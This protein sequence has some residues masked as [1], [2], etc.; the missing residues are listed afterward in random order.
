MRSTVL[1]SEEA[2]APICQGRECQRESQPMSK[3]DFVADYN[4]HARKLKSKL[5]QDQ[6]M[7][8]AIGGQ[9]IPFG[10]LEMNLL[11]QYGLIGN[12]LVIDVGCGSGRLAN[13]LVRYPKL[14]YLGTDVVEQFLDYARKIAERPDWKFQRTRGLEIPA[15][16]SS[17]DFVTFF[18]VFTHLLHEESYTYLQEALR[19]LKPGGAA[20]VSFLDFAV[21]S[22]WTV[23]EANLRGVHNRK[24][25]L[26]QFMSKDLLRAWAA[27]LQLELV[28][29]FDGDQ[30]H[31]RV[32]E[33]VTL[34]DGTVLTGLAS[35]GQSV[36]VFKKRA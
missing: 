13:A 26:N 33:P 28:D 25:P 3:H 17:A 8:A 1:Q 21:D 32:P 10:I 5:G 2:A 18:S 34:D 12:E 27:R 35:L 6:G 23:F 11:Q 15:A 16:D 9:F 31:I 24:H 20:L 29:V 19:V 7:R 14:R 36:A 4:E 30:P 22:H